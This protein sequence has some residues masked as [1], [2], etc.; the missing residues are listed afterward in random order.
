MLLPLVDFTFK[1]IGVE[2]RT[3]PMTSPPIYLNLQPCGSA[4]AHPQYDA[5]C[6]FRYRKPLVI[7]AGY[8]VGPCVVMVAV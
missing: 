6:R 3:P 2:L 8:S 5:L 4:L 7:R 1:V